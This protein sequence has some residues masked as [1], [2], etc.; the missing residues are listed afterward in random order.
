MNRVG[1]HF[2]IQTGDKPMRFSSLQGRLGWL[3]LSFFLLVSVSAGLALW[4]LASQDQDALLVNL[5]GRQRMLI[6]QM[7]RLA[8]E[9][10]RAET[11]AAPAVLHDA[12]AL[13]QQTLA[14]LA[15]GGAAPYPAEPGALVPPARQPQVIAQ[16]DRLHGEWQ[17][18]AAQLDALE[19]AP[20]G[21][22]A[23]S[24]AAQAVA[25]QSGHLLDEADALARL[26][27]EAAAGKVAR[28]RAL[29]ATFLA[30]ALLLLLL[31]GW[32]V[33]RWVLAPLRQLDQAAER[34]GA[35]DLT[36]PVRVQG[37]H[38]IALLSRTMETMRARLL[39]SRGELLQLTASL[40]AR[41]AQR[42]AELD[43]LNEVSRE[44]SAQ[45]DGA[46]VLDSITGKAQGLLGADMAVLCLLDER[47]D[48]L[49]LRSLSGPQEAVRAQRVAARRGLSPHVLSADGALACGSAGCHGA[50][51]MLSDSYSSSHLAAPLRVGDRVVGALCV[52]SPQAG[53]FSA[54]SAEILAKLANTAAVALENARL[55]AQAERV[56]TLEERSR[57]AAEMHD[58]LGQTLGYL[59]L[60][61]DQVVDFLAQGQDAAA[62][63]RLSATRAAIERATGDVRRAIGQLLDETPA[64]PDLATRLHALAEDFGRENHLAVR[65]DSTAA[66]RCSP[67]VAEQVLNIAREALHNAARHAD[68]SAV[69]V[70]LAQTNGHCQV[71]VQDDGRGFDPSLPEPAGHFGLQVMQ[72]RAAHIAGQLTVDSAPGRG[73]CVRL[74]WPAGQ[75]Q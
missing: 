16:L 51:Q 54:E 38:E 37:P 33:R 32:L 34:I 25:A 36:T 71:A 9:M 53:R 4:S 47:G 62:L 30:S 50:C 23:R 22:P 8:A 66:P 12:R 75:G 48:W 15:D 28:L 49:H 43:A 67:E 24:Q 1:Y 61:T 14:A 59:G 65:W 70:Q 39:A 57:I 73:T 35:D 17:A 19:N 60:M 46:H 74:T 31:G 68:A 44:I 6:Q 3:F 45:L 63:E 41:V 29:Q 55:Y 21:S 20:P 56:A 72:A 18:F 58:G 7:S 11:P 52:G 13:F 64:L 42:T 2:P 5:A 27:Q 26:Y 69:T 40:E 10:E